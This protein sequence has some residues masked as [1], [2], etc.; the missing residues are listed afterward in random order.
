MSLPEPITPKP[1][2]AS[3]KPKEKSLV[4]QL[5]HECHKRRMN[6]AKKMEPLSVAILASASILYRNKDTEF[7]FRQDSDFYYLTG[8]TEPDMVMV[9]KKGPGK[10]SCLV[11]CQPKCPEK[12]VWSGPRLGVLGVKQ[13]LALSKKVEIIVYPIEKLKVKL[14]SFLKNIKKIYCSDNAKK[15][16]KT[17]G[18]K[19]AK[20]TKKNIDPL[21]HELRLIKSP[22]EI[23]L[24]QKAADIS[25]AG[26]RRIMEYIRDKIKDSNNNLKS[27]LNQSP[28]LKNSSIKYVQENSLEAEFLHESYHRGCHAMAYPC[29]VAGGKNACILHYTK[30]DQP[31]KMGELVLIDAGAEYQYYASDITRTL[32]VN[33]KF[34]EEQRA[35]YQ[36]VLNA[37]KEAIA[38]IRPGV[39]FNQ[40]QDI[41]VRILVEGLVELKI[42]K[43][44]KS[45]EK[46]IKEK[47]YRRFYMHNSGHWL[48][49]D[50]HDVGGYKEKNGELKT[51]QPGMVLTVEPGLYIA[52][53]QKDVDPEWRGIGVR[54]EDDI[55]VTKDGHQDLTKNLPKEIEDIENL[56]RS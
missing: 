36:L 20:H 12:E 37:Q 40:M 19:I 17:C 9:L 39:K 24:M 1:K 50:V 42:L 32:P 29:I 15:V 52:P 47:A 35:I 48:G 16:L 51:L 31:L 5:K 33:G 8:L 13:A 22:Y 30:N 55:L 54:I 41:I 3:Q 45:I 6:L 56:M 34:S 18:K 14:P 23:S 4:E 49:L 28:Q 2:E 43:S 38:A 21:V 27:A 7:P 53:D 10:I 25:V 46:L 11:F 44:K 26:H